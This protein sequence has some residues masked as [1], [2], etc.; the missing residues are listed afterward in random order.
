[1]HSTRDQPVDSSSNAEPTPRIQVHC[2]ASSLALRVQDIL[3]QY[4]YLTNRLAR[5]LLGL[6]NSIVRENSW[7]VRVSLQ[8]AFRLSQCGQKVLCLYDS[9]TAKDRGRSMPADPHRSLLRHTGTNHVRHS[10]SPEI[11]EQKARLSNGL[12]SLPPSA[13]EVTHRLSF[14][15]KHS[16]TD[17][18]AIRTTD[19]ACLPTLLYQCGQGGR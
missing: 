14:T 19:K 16:I 18:R 3:S 17:T 8:S 11:V 6:V 15:V 12:D 5:Y 7:F 1:T 10:G 2:L 4:Y 9:V 13:P